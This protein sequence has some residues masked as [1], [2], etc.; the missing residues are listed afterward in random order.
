MPWGDDGSTPMH[1]KFSGREVK[2]IMQAYLSKIA[3]ISQVNTVRTTSPSISFVFKLTNCNKNEADVRIAFNEIICAVVA[4]VNALGGKKISVQL[5]TEYPITQTFH[6]GE[7]DVGGKLDYCTLLKRML[8]T[9]FM[10]C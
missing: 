4:K 2:S 1:Y 6:D 9:L 3:I 10:L 5:F 8:N 7:V